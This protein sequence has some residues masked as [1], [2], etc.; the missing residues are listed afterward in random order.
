M[1]D[2]LDYM[3]RHGP[4]WDEPS[5]SPIEVFRRNFWLSS[6]YDPLSY[7]LRERIGVDRIM[8]EMD[9]P[10]F[11]SSWPDTQAILGSQI[12]GL[13]PAEIDQI[14]HANACELY[15]HPV[16]EGWGAPSAAAV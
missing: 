10:H 2:R 13:S 12:E 16:P 14:T 15:R 3:S 7:G 1:L 4:V 5:I 8:V 6:F 9:Y 11:D